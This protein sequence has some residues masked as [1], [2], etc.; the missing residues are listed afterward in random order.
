MKT[1]LLI[2]DG[3]RWHRETLAAALGYEGFQ[4]EHTGDA[5]SAVALLARHHFHL[6]LLDPSAPATGGWKTVEQMHQ[7]NPELPLIV[8]VADEGD[9]RSTLLTGASRIIRKP[10]DFF[11][12]LSAIE[13]ALSPPVNALPGHNFKHPSTPSGYIII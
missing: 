13:R 11:A 12:L 7:L 4:A 10:M 5:A 3:D 8:F 1:S 6:A 2:L 9:P